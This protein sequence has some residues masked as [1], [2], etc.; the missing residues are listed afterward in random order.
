M[1]T[2][3]Y[4][5]ETHYFVKLGYA[6]NGGEHTENYLGQGAKAVIAGGIIVLVFNLIVIVLFGLEETPTGPEEGPQVMVRTGE[7]A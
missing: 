6:Y 4:F 3:L 1:I 2:T 5:L 7:K